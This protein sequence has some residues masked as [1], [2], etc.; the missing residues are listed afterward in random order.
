[1]FVL[2]VMIQKVIIVGIME[3]VDIIYKISA[4][5]TAVAT[6]LLTY[7]IYKLS[8]ES[9]R[10]EN[11]MQKM[12]EL[13]YQIEDDSSAMFDILSSNSSSCEV[14]CRQ[15]RRRIAVSCTLMVYYLMRIPGYYKDRTQFEKL[16]VYITYEPTKM[17]YYEELSAH[18]EKFCWG[19]RKNKKKASRYY[20]G[21]DKIGY[22]DENLL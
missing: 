6:L 1:M 3:Y 5:I 7:Y 19:I 16:L 13:Y 10:K 8:S 17:D 11:Y 4:P 22:P 12:A 14:Q 21:L 2:H 18:F 9:N 20:M 15:F